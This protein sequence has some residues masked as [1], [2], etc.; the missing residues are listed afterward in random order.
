[1][2]QKTEQP[3]YSQLLSV[4]ALGRGSH[5]AGGT[6]AYPGGPACLEWL[7]TFPALAL[8]VLCSGNPSVLGNWDG[9]S[10]S[11]HQHH[12]GVPGGHAP[13][14]PVTALRGGLQVL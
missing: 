8:R 10:P 1:M 2:E 6:A 11:F 12:S 9:R 13:G 3:Y 4:E 5:W 14:G 7:R